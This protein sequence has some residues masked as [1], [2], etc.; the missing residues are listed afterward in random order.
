MNKILNNVNHEINLY[1][2]LIYLCLKNVFKS[3][4][5][6]W[7]QAHV[8]RELI[9]TTLYLFLCEKFV[10]NEESFELCEIFRNVSLVQNVTVLYFYQAM[11]F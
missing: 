3:N 2:L 5:P 7:L 11:D 1:C 8:F 4:M 10:L 9:L 6:Q